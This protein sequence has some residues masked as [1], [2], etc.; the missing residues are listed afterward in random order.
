MASVLPRSVGL[1]ASRV[2][3][4]RVNFQPTTGARLT[5]DVDELPKTGVSD[6]VRRLAEANQVVYE[7]TLLDDWADAVT[8]A[9]GDDAKLD[10]TEKLL[11]A[12][13]KKQVING[14]QLTRLLNNYMEESDSVRP[15]QR[16]SNPRPPS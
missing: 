7:R 8:R 3:A 6:F 10:A 11:V 15:V 2:V 4:N 1:I 12:L 14:R 16:V 5:A 13:A 9:S